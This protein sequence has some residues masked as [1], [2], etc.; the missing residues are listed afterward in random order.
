M[1]FVEA[2][3]G[4]RSPARLPRRGKRAERKPRASLC[5]H[6]A[7]DIDNRDPQV[8]IPMSGRRLSHHGSKSVLHCQM[9]QSLRVRLNAYSKAT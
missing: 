5:A 2:P 3:R 7:A 6:T 1:C 8:I 4:L 9:S